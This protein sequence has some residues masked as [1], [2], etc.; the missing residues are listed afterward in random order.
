MTLK[1]YLTLVKNQKNIMLYYDI[2]TYQ[3]NE[4][5]GEIEPSYY[6]N[7]VY[8]VCVGYFYEDQLYMQGYSNFFDFFIDVLA[9]YQPLKKKPLIY[10]NAHNGDK[11]DVHFMRWALRYYFKDLTVKNYFLMQAVDEANVESYRLKEI[12]KAEKENGVILEKR[13]KSKNNLAMIFF[14][15]GVRFETV[16]NWQKTNLSIKTLGEKLKRLGV[17]TSDDLKTDYDYLKYNLRDDLTDEQ[18][19]SYANDIFNHLSD[20]ELVYIRNDVKILAYSVKYYSELFKGFSYDAK[21]FTQNILR[22]YAVDPLTEWQLLGRFGKGKAK[23][24]INNSDYQFMGM[25][26]YD[27]L[28]PFYRGGLNFYNDRYLEKIIDEPCFAIDLNSSYPYVM[29]H[30]NVPTFLKS[31]RG[32]EEETEIVISED[33]DYHL[34]Q[35]TKKEFDHLMN[36]MESKVGIKM[37]I[38]YYTTSSDYVNINTYTLKVLND[39]FHCGI[40]KI[41]VMSEVVY[42]CLPFNARDKIS[43]NYRIKEQGK[44]HYKLDYKSPYQ[45]TETEEVND[46]PLS[47][48]EIANAKVTLNGLYGIPALR[49]HF[50]LFRLIGED[51]VNIEN[52]FKNNERQIIFSIFVTSVA[53]WNLL[54]PLKDLTGEEIDECFLYCDTDSLYLKKKIEDKLDHSLF[55]DRALGAYSYDEDLITKFC[56]I[57][58]KKYAFVYNDEIHV[59]SAGIPNG[60]FNLDVPFEEFVR[61]QFRS[62]ITIKNTKSIYNR[63]GVISIYE[64]QTELKKGRK[65]RLFMDNPALEN[66]VNQMLKDIKATIDDNDGADDVLYIESGLGSFS[67]SELNPVKNSVADKLPLIY[68]LSAQ[69]DVK[70]RLQ[71]Y[72]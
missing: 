39:I 25:N 71:S 49:S 34:Y 61:T 26:F 44:S 8:S 41:K 31:Y 46:E 72:L 66:G 1:E 37:L 32:Y 24:E 27:Y 58:H 19:I 23:K 14:L 70:N 43:E 10:L 16:D 59:R 47:P 68:Y 2:E 52:G 17:L 36:A 20:E 67:M 22:Y 12:T 4:A 40:E 50:N 21:T 63:Q 30:F 56:V 6:K 7:M 42:E 28:K 54:Q 45:M 38:K 35:V 60:A 29:H 65:Y 57:N 64:S 33:N 13:V 48:E 51:Y 3:Y 62:G 53:L 18:A 15:G 9:V 5:E 11:Y 69:E 55:D